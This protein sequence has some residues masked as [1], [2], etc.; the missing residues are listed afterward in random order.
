MLFIDE[1]KPCVT[2]L[3]LQHFSNSEEIFERYLTGVVL[4]FDFTL[5]LYYPQAVV[6]AVLIFH[7]LTASGTLDLCLSLLN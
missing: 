3:T 4:I 5:L 1:W 2:R 6:T 7:V